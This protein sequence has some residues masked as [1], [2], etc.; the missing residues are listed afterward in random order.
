[1][2]TRRQENILQYLIGHKEPVYGSELAP[3]LGITPR[4]LRTEMRVI[5][6][7]LSASGVQIHSSPRAGYWLDEADRTKL[8]NWQG[9][10]AIPDGLPSLPEEREIYLY[11]RLLATRE[12]L[13]MEALA[14]ELYTSKTTIS[15]DIHSMQQLVSCVDGVV[16]D[17]SRKNG[18][19]LRG[20]EHHIRQLISGILLYYQ[21]QF[22]GYLHKAIGHFYPQHGTGIL[23]RLYYLLVDALLTQDIVITGPSMELLAME[24]FLIFQ[25][26]QLGY[27]LTANLESQYKEVELPVAAMEELFGL[28]LTEKDRISMLQLLRYKR[29]LKS[30]IMQEERT[31]RMQEVAHRFREKV[32][33]EYG[34]EFEQST[35]IRDH[36]YAML[37]YHHLTFRKRTMLVAE[38]QQNYPFAYEVACCIIPIAEEVLGYHLQENE[39]SRLAVRLVVAM[40]EPPQRKRTLV[41]VDS[42]SYSELLRFKLKHYFSRKIEFCGT[43]PAYQL[44]N[45]LQNAEEPIELILATMPLT[46]HPDAD[47][48]HISP[49]LNQQDINALNDYFFRNNRSYRKAPHL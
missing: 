17:I 18:L 1:M 42:A 33:E 13:T 30:P 12:Y 39:I 16:L 20:E 32:K 4:T 49:I 37:T 15:K 43:C 34:F 31:Q 27:E 24:Y 19:C 5:G 9:K 21:M 41:V 8:A 45:L 44:D 48:L 26:K 40:D 3:A 25:R 28:S 2:L 10:A 11:F 22:M 6:E 38:I 35:F 14:N 23:D 46:S 29:F 47:I 36:I 7:H